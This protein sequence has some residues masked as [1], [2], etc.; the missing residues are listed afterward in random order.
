MFIGYKHLFLIGIAKYK[1]YCE[2]ADA[3]HYTNYILL[4]PWHRV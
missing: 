2:D 1:Y 3:S 4:Q